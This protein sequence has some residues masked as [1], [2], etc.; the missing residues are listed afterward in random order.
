MVVDQLV[1]EVVDLVR[2]EGDELQSL[3]EAFHFILP[4]DLHF[5]H[6]AEKIVEPVRASSGSHDLDTLTHFLDGDPVESGGMV[7]QR[8]D[9]LDAFI[10][11]FC[12]EA[13]KI[14]GATG[15]VP[16]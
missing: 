1:R 7:Y 5:Q 3:D 12:L 10:D 9:E 14:E 4:P 8:L 15:E 6:A 13:D 2:N 16:D 11:I